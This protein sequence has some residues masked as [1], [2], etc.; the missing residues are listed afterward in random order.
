[1]YFATI[2]CGTTNSRVYIINEKSEI[3]GQAEKK[4]G[5]RNTAITGNKQVLKTGL[6]EVFYTAL[7]ITNLKLSDIKFIISSGMITSEIG[8]I[9]IPHIWAPA[10]S[11]QLATHI[12]KVQDTSIFPVEIPIYFICGIKNKYNLQNSTIKSVGNLDFMRGEETQVVGLFILHDIE[13]PLTIVV[14]SSH[15][16]FIPID[17]NQNILG[18]ITTVSGQVYE[19]IIKETFVGKSIRANNDFDAEN[20]FNEDIVNSAFYWVK[21]SGFLRSL[22]LPRFMDVLLKTEWYE[23]E[24]FVESVIAS[25]DL[26]AMSKLQDFASDKTFILIGPERRCLIYQYLLKEKKRIKKI[27]KITDKRDIDHLSITGSIHLAKLAGLMT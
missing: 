2:D 1:M 17:K 8:L 19:A 13:P 22:L 14:L 26:E 4:I 21:E 27:L 9:E 16:K 18:S 7:E 5:V 24:L 12:K 25:E 15:T 20:Y 11:Y 23:R 6:V 10:G 3:L